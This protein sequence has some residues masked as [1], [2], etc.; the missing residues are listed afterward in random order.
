MA[1]PTGPRGT[2]VVLEAG[3]LAASTGALAALARLALAAR[4]TGHRVRLRGASPALR[5]LLDR[6]G[7]AGEFEWEAEQRE[8][9]G[10]VEE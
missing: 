10:G 1:A 6:A 9:G 5:A 4:R 8:E 2:V 7:L 3:A